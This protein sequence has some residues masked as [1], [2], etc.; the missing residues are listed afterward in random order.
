[1]TTAGDARAFPACGERCDPTKKDFE[2]AGNG[3]GARSGV[4]VSASSVVKTRASQVVE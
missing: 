3:Y 4:E 2:W 1:M